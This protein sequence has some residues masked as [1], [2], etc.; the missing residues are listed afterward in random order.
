MKALP[1]SISRLAGRIRRVALT[2]PGCRPVPAALDAIRR[3]DVITLGPGS[4]YTSLLPNLLVTGIADA[5]RKASGLRVYIGNLMTQPGETTGFSASDHL[6]AFHQHAGQGLFDVAILNPAR[7]GSDPGTLA[8]VARLAERVIYVSCGPETLARDLD[9]LAAHGMRVREL[10]G[11]RAGLHLRRAEQEL[12]C[13]ARSGH[14]RR[15]RRR[16][17]GLFDR[18]L[19]LDERSR[20]PRPR[21][22]SAAPSTQ[23]TITEPRGRASGP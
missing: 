4:L 9:V 15:R 5:V 11:L 19:A 1:S 14:H 22:R 2:P 17:R 18:G 21:A 6:E 3:A 23:V 16:L 13:G 12:R 10:D 7:R 20:A 8:R